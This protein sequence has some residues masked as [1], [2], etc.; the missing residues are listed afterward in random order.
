MSPR[1]SK[2]STAAPERVFRVEPCPPVSV[3]PA[4]R[5]QP[6]VVRCDPSD[7]EMDP[8]PHY[9]GG[10]SVTLD[11]LAWHF[12]NEVAVGL[13]MDPD[14]QRGHVWTEAQ[15]V[16]YVEYM[17][18]GGK[19]GVDIITAHTGDLVNDKSSPAGCR[20][21]YYALVDGKQRLRA[22]LRF[23]SDE[24]AVFASPRRPEGYRWSGLSSRFHRIAQCV[25][26]VRIPMATRADI[27]KLY[28]KF[29]AGGTPHTADEIDKVRALLANEGEGR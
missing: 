22:L 9:E 18:R 28:I 24:I 7:D 16:A 11:Y 4:L 3:M 6:L 13:D 8:F 15:Q 5:P 20:Y 17:L 1:P 27:L 21:P 12:D 19:T 25:R 26:V 2:K 14:F 10:T 29:N 23:V